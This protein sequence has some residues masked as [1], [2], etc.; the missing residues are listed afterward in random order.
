MSTCSWEREVRQ[1]EGSIGGSESGIVFVASWLNMWWSL[2][3]PRDWWVL[4]APESFD[5]LPTEIPEMLWGWVA[6]FPLARVHPFARGRFSRDF[7]SPNQLASKRPY[8]SISMNIFRSVY[9]ILLAVRSRPDVR[10]ALVWAEQPP[11]APP[12]SAINS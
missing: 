8:R 4:K 1:A 10:C 12:R 7:A 6:V 11:G 3:G 9:N 5:C 2:Y